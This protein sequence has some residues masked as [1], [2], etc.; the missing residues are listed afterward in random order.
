MFWQA[1]YHHPICSIVIII[2]TTIVIMKSGFS[3]LF[4]VIA[5]QS[6]SQFL[7]L[8]IILSTTCWSWMRRVL[9]MLNP[10]YFQLDVRTGV[11]NGLTTA[12]V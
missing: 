7:V 9:S 1:V 6:R 3:D 12:V 8:V 5:I 11:D 4:F 10:E 2:T